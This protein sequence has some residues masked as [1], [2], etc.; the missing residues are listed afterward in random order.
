MTTTQ[1]LKKLYFNYTKKYLNKILTS[2]FFTLLLAGSTSSVA[3]LLDPA[4]KHLFVEQT[5]VYPSAPPP[6][7]F[8]LNKKDP[9][10]SMWQPYGPSQYPSAMS[11]PIFRMEAAVLD[12][13][14]HSS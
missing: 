13:A 6:L 3:Y 2:V 1:I 11:S 8:P 5:G 10:S 14:K 12:A 4:I 9:P 7:T